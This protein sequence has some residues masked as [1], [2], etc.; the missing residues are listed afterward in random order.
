MNDELEN[1]RQEAAVPYL[2]Y[3]LVFCVRAVGC[4]CVCVCVLRYKHTKH[5]HIEVA[6]CR[7]INVQAPGTYSYHWA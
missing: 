6:K 1:M 3:C 2:M 5:K 4:V 7:V